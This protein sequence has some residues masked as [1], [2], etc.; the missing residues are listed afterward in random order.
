MVALRGAKSV[1]STAAGTAL[2]R[3]WPTVVH[4]KMN[5]MK[6][7]TRKS[8]VAMLDL[9]IFNRSSDMGTSSTGGLLE[10]L[11]LLRRNIK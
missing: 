1:F 9:K 2:S 8:I 5:K 4:G 6:L 11:L 10:N 7:W 3:P